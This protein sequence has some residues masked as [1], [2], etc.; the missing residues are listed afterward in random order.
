M[1][2]RV[3]EQ[4]DDVTLSHFMKDIVEVATV[5]RAHEEFPSWCKLQTSV[6]RFL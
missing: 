3:L 4:I 6:F 2:K 1:S 5:T